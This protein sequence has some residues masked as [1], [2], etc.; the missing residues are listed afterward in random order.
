MFE[1]VKQFGPGSAP[2]GEPYTILCY[3]DSN[4]Y[5]YN[6]M[7]Q[8]RHGINNRW[9]MVLQKLLGDEYRVI[10][11]GCNGRTAYNIV[12]NNPWKTGDYGMKA[13]L[14]SHKPVDLIIFMLGSNDLKTLYDSRPQDIAEAMAAMLREAAQFMLDQQEF[15]PDLLLISPPEIDERIGDSFFGDEFDASS[16]ERSRQMADALRKTAADFSFEGRTCH[17]L[18]AARY[19]SPSAHDCLHL[20]ADQHGALARAIH[21]KILKDIKKSGLL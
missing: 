2:K 1:Q 8:K 9:P 21:E 3:G 12:E 15:V 20:E 19:A 7:T 5:G 13:L 14:N 17:F 16:A 6:P 4:T 18:D 10:E 11:E